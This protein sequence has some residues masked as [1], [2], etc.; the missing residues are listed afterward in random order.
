MEKTAASLIPFENESKSKQIPKDFHVKSFNFT[1][2]KKHLRRFNICKTSQC[3][4]NTSE[5]ELA[6]N[7]YQPTLQKHRKEMIQSLQMFD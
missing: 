2:L 7:K 6:A 4:V 3:A 1:A 5:A